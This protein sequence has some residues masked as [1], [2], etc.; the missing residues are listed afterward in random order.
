MGSFFGNLQNIEKIQLKFDKVYPNRKAMEEAL[1]VGDGVFIDRLVLIEYDDHSRLRRRG[2]LKNNY[3]PEQCEIYMDSTCQTPYKLRELDVTLEYKVFPN[4]IFYVTKNNQTYY[5]YCMDQISNDGNALF[6]QINWNRSDELITDYELNYK[7]D[8]EKYAL[9]M[10][11]QGYD[12]TIWRKTLKNGKEA[13]QMIA[14]LNT[15]MPI[16][17]LAEKAPSIYPISPYFGEDSTNQKYTINLQPNWGFKIKEAETTID[18]NGD[19]VILSDQKV[20][21]K[22]V[23]RNEQT[24]REEIIT[25]DPYD[26]AIYYNQDGFDYNNIN[27]SNELNEISLLPTG[28]SGKLYYNHDLQ[29]W[30]AQND[31]QE[32]K[33]HLPEIG[34]TVAKIWNLAYGDSI[35]NGSNKRN[36]DINWD[37]TEG[38]RLIK[39]AEDGSGFRYDT[40][41][42]QSIAGCINSVHDLMGMIVSEGD[43]TLAE[44]DMDRI[45]YGDKLGRSKKSYFIKTRKNTYTPLKH[46]DLQG[47]I[48][49]RKYVQLTQYE[50]NKYHT[51]TNDNFYFEVNDE[52]TPGTNHY[53]LIPQQM[54]LTTWEKLKYYYKDELLNYI[55]DT[56]DYADFNK[57]YYSIQLTQETYLE[58]EGNHPKTE[59]YNPTS[60][61]GFN[62]PGDPDDLY[63]YKYYSG[64]LYI[65]AV[66]ND[67]GELV[68]HIIE[69]E[70]DDLLLEDVSYFYIP[71]YIKSESYPEGADPIVTLKWPNGESITP[72]N[73]QSSNYNVEFLIFEDN[74]YYKED[75]ELGGYKCIHKL[76]D[77]DNLTIYY[78]ITATLETGLT[79]HY[80]IPNFYYYK[81]G[82]NDYI[83]ATT[84]EK[85]ESINGQT[86]EYYVLNGTEPIDITFYESGK[87]YYYNNTLHREVLDNNNIMKIFPDK[88]LIEDELG[89]NGEIYFLKLNAYVI[90]DPTGILSIGSIWNAG[91]NI[92]ETLELGK[93]YQGEDIDEEGNELP[94]GSL[95]IEQ[96]T[97]RMYEWK[98]LQGFARTLNTIHGLILKINQFFKF[99]DTLTRDRSTVQGCLNS[100]NDVLNQFNTLKPGDISIVDSYGRL[101]G[102]NLVT[103]SWFNVN[104]N[105][106]LNRPNI[107]IEHSNSQNIAES[108]KGEAANKDLKFGE[109]FKTIGFGVDEKGHVIS[110]DFQEYDI[111]LPSLAIDNSST[112]DIITDLRLS[113]DK[114]KLVITKDSIGSLLLNNYSI[115]TEKMDLTTNDTLNEAIGKLEFRIKT[116]E[117][118]IAILE[119]T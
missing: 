67:N 84:E 7:I 22:Y 2:Y 54:N 52:P 59:F 16:F 81:Q 8:F 4:D 103:D 70:K 100:L 79:N 43:T 107:S 23:G 29:D 69:L 9:D 53:E 51:K 13:Y 88:D 90:N 96:K 45:Y 116:L 94:P 39:E 33:I 115:G 78:T 58:S 14:S 49:S 63:P 71:K 3:N 86:L 62:D 26:G 89:P 85:V 68:Y 12:S 48:N 77:I 118:K 31:I 117:E 109:S 91:P 18:T 82:I 73:L 97:A 92:P 10:P 66:E 34:N 5:F 98:E 6:K 114:Q 15:N 110:A 64:Y 40:Y 44:A 87:Y 36:T 104:I 28:Q 105:Y 11:D 32:L 30:E 106:D 47:Y 61:Q 37:S 74:K 19:E 111:K 83:L 27:I 55:L 35:A 25:E 72:S 102:A 50:A 112:G 20:Q 38:L 46:E 65:K 80:Y 95:T 101:T 42:T 119:Q 21:Y 57:D 76:E 1:N 41:N 99:D 17:S 24:G 113:N 60:P 56:N 108:K 75:K 93:L